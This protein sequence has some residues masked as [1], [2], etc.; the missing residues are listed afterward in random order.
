MK[1]GD[2]QRRKVA[3]LQWRLDSALRAIERLTIERDGWQELATMLARDT[4][5]QDDTT[6]AA[7]AQLEE[8][9]G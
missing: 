1:R 8:G 6:S 5:P 7:V 4:Q 9:K 3:D 2:F